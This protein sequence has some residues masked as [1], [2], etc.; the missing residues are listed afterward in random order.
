VDEQ[1]K[2]ALKLQDSALSGSGSRLLDRYELGEQLGSGGMG[3]VFKARQL[4]TGRLVAVKLMSEAFASADAIKRFE[5]EMKAISRLFHPNLVALVDFGY[6]DRQCPVLVQE[7]I[8]GSSLESILRE[9]KHLSAQEIID[10]F[11]KICQGLSHVHEKGLVHRDLKPSNIMIAADE[12]GQLQVKIVDFGIAKSSQQTQS[13]TKTGDVLGS[14]LYMSPEQALA[15]KVDHRSDIYS[16]GCM[17]YE[18]AT[19]LPPF[20]G[21]SAL[22]SLCMRL[23]TDPAPFEKVAPFYAF[24]D[25]LEHVVMRAMERQP[26]RRYQTAAALYA[27]LRNLE[28]QVPRT[29]GSAEGIRQMRQQAE[30]HQRHHALTSLAV[31][32]GITGL[33]V[34]GAGWILSQRH[35]SAPSRTPAPASTGTANTAMQT[36]IPQAATTNQTE[37]QTS[38]PSIASAASTSVALH[39]DKSV[40]RMDKS[41]AVIKAKP[42]LP[43]YIKEQLEDAN[44]PVIARSGGKNQLPP[45]PAPPLPP[46]IVNKPQAL[47]DFGTTLIRAGRAKEAAEAWYHASEVARAQNDMPRAAAALIGIAEIQ[48][49]YQT[50]FASALETRRNAAR[51]CLGWLHHPPIKNMVADNL[52]AMADD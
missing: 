51:L 9:R 39:A 16:L 45:A 12:T 47:L 43:A 18:A 7:F 17:L 42:E 2:D 5:H 52:A 46:S 15:Q 35:S 36:R 22:Q 34:L 24:P 23:N 26:Q 28:R 38:K 48:E 13:L 3:R 33:F 29:T 8:P 14:P 1:S 31:C 6:D 4:A 21:D 50:D 25:G 44:P 32:I 49:S 40:K 20:Q 19:G 27:D 30:L 11:C 37:Q 10:I 41:K